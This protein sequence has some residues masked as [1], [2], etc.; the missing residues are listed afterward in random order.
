MSPLSRT[1][2]CY[3]PDLVV[4]DTLERFLEIEDLTNYAEVSQ[5]FQPVIDLVAR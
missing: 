5:A 3:A 2:Q 1:A 4:I